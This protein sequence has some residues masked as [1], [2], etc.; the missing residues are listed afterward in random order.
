MVRA[1]TP[2]LAVMMVAGCAD[3]AAPLR[4]SPPPLARSEV[5]PPPPGSGAIFNA[6]VPY[7]PLHQGLRAR[8]VGDLVTIVLVEDTRSRRSVE[9]S[10]AR[11]GGASL[12]LPAEGPLALL[13]ADALKMSS[14]ASFNGSAAARQTSSI[15]GTVT[16]T[17]VAV[18]PGG[19]AQVEGE[20]RMVLSQGEEWVQFTGRL[21]LADIDAANRIPSTL[22]A[23]ARIRHSGRGALQQASRPGWLSRF[24]ARV[25][26]F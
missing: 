4:L 17:L 16:V 19:T 18:E 8:R 11:Q 14:G 9:A 12:T 2:L 10:S 25:A 13:G 20:K 26:P 1:L 7:A 24:F 15:A 5:P 6:A 23:D 21:R 22:I 3:P